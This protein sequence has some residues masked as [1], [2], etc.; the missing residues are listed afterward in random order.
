[1]PTVG[2]TL[3]AGRSTVQAAVRNLSAE[4]LFVPTRLMLPVGTEVHIELTEP[5]APSGG[6][7]VASGCVVWSGRG[8]L[9]V[10][11]QPGLAVRFD[12]VTLG[13]GLLSGLGR[14]RTSLL[15]SHPALPRLVPLVLLPLSTLPDEAARIAAYRPSPLLAQ[16][17]EGYLSAGMRHR[18]LYLWHMVRLGI[19]AEALP[20]V[21]P[22][23]RDGL[24]D[25]KTLG[26]MVVTLLDDL[27]DEAHDRSSL[28]RAIAL[29]DRRLTDQPGRAPA[30]AGPYLD[31]AID[32]WE[33]MW[34]QIERLPRYA[35]LRHLLCF[36]WHQIINSMRY[37]LLVS[38][39]PQAQNLSEHEDYMPHGMHMVC[40]A[41]LDLMGSPGFALEDL[42]V[43]RRAARAAQRMGRIGNLVTTW[44]RELANGDFSSGVFSLLLHRR[45]LTPGD[46]SALSRDEL[47]QRVREACPQRAFLLDWES[48]RGYLLSL[49]DQCVT[50]DL[51]QFVKGLEQLLLLQLASQGQV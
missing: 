40:N 13:H 44:E 41:T 33:R 16:A 8:P 19:E 24:N 42:S 37:A 15:R 29:L 26:A 45:V 1:L 51:E 17:V 32:L 38:E 14:R 4:G 49:Q 35:E 20:C 48:L 31:L 46:L 21:A 23:L 11:A 43:V 28:E 18:R 25:I 27:A 36:D 10:S 50:V 22:E 34:G 30:A 7:A 6:R 9:G 2:C 39:L 5:A 47:L 12:E 3:S